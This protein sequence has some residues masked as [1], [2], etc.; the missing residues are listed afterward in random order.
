[1]LAPSAIFTTLKSTTSRAAY[2][3]KRRNLSTISHKTVACFLLVDFVS[4]RSDKRGFQVENN[5]FVSFNICWRSECHISYKVYIYL[6]I[7]IYIYIYIYKYFSLN[8]SEF[9]HLLA[10]VESSPPLSIH[11]FVGGLE[12]VAV[13]I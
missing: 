2:Q 7:Y 3:S 9:A 11:S 8:F 1:M 12:I 10:I 5:V 6:Y 4:H 13:A